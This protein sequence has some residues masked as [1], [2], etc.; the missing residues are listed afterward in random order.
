VTNRSG[1][2]ELGPTL[3]ISS[4]I[5]QGDIGPF[6]D[7]V[8]ECRDMAVALGCTAAVNMQCRLVGGRPSIFE[9]NPRFSGTTSLRAMAGYNEPEELLRCAVLGEPPRRDFP[10]RS[11]HIYRGLQE[12]ADFGAG[13]DGGPA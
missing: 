8:R 13:S 3:I 10:Y 11:G 6:P 2:A 5:S 7:V 4:G 12:V 1:R 9:I